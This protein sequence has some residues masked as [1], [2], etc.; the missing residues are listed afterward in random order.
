[1]ED[2]DVVGV[3]VGSVDEDLHGRKFLV[4]AYDLRQYKS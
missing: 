4:M 1:M 3:P 2:K